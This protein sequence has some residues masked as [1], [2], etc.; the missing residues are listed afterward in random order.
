MS[1]SR[2]GPYHYQLVQLGFV[3]QARARVR[4]AQARA[5]ALR[6]PGPQ[7]AAL[8][9][10]ALIE[11]R[12]GKAERVAERSAQMLALAEEYALMPH[13]RAVHLWLSGWAQAR[14][15]DPHAGYRRINEGYE[16]AVPFGL[17]ALASEART[18]GAEAL[19]LAGDWVAARRQVVEAMQCADAI[20]ERQYL[21]QLLLLDAR[22][23]DGFGEPDRA[24]ESI[25]RAIAE[26]RLQEAPWLELAALSARCERP[27]V[28]AKDFAAL[29][30]VV[31]Q[32]TEG[33]DTAQ[34]ARARELLKRR[35]GASTSARR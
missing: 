18:Y 2:W 32:L 26:A 15:G 1:G 3:N 16:Q 35:R 34:V 4:E 30:H 7:V 28:S 25:R 23:A 9:F 33:L 12:I 10:E 8:W 5:R 17:R 6:A 31:E 11:V 24:R 19:A 20:G 14:L 21:T 29:A 27:D 22:I 13:V